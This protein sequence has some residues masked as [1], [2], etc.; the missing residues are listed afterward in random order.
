MF[1]GSSSQISPGYMPAE[2]AQIAAEDDAISQLGVWAAC[3]V[4]L[5]GF[6]GLYFEEE[7]LGQLRYVMYFAPLI[8]GA[9]LL[10][11][12]APRLNWPPLAMLAAY[13]LISL[14]TIAFYELA[15][16]F[17]VN[18][19]LICLILLGFIPAA[20]VS[21]KQIRFLLY[22]TLPCSIAAFAL[23]SH[24]S[25]RIVEIL[26]S[27]T[28]TGLVDAYDNHD[29]LLAPMFAIYFQLAGATW[30]M[31]LAVAMCILGGKRIGFLALLIGLAVGVIIRRTG[32]LQTNRSR[33]AAMLL[34]VGA[35]N[36]VG[37][38]FIALSEMVHS[39]LGLKVHIE[40]VMLGRH[41]ISTELNRIISEKSY[42]EWMFGSGAGTADYASGTQIK[43]ASGDLPH[44]DW[45]K[46]FFDYGAVGS[47]LATI[48]MAL[49]FS[50]SQTAVAIGVASSI[51][52]L[53]DNV[54]IYV[55]YQFPIALIVACAARRREQEE[56]ARA[57]P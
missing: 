9:T 26:M 36:I 21:D 29:G 46:I 57:S 24:G 11:S 3:V 16:G 38:N 15:E 22:A 17:V 56:Q 6:L 35:I 31:L 13:I 28:G 47:I 18:T 48:F 5:I 39:A 54:M 14:S 32:L 44:N 42:Y 43:G 8:L 55:Y 34:A 20:A 12:Q 52:M 37:L 25:A 40:D 7:G 30:Q 50:T 10:F 1:A 23:T 2:V 49:V 41:N 33:F 45:L 51:I 4:Y 27:G 53:T 19:G